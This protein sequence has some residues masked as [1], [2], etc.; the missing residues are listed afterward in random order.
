VSPAQRKALAIVVAAYDDPQQR[1]WPVKSPHRWPVWAELMDVRLYNH[2]LPRIPV[3]T[4]DVL[5]REGLIETK[6]TECVNVLP[7]GA[8]CEHWT[9]VRVAPTR[10]G[11][12]ALKAA[13]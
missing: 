6:R 7:H 9:Q 5:E 8:G 3:K 13:S 12:T 4:L 11:R 2:K 10:K 1:K